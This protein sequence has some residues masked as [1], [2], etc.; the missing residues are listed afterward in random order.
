M[1]LAAFMI[2]FFACKLQV[3]SLR[4]RPPSAKLH[5]SEE[6]ICIYGSAVMNELLVSNLPSFSG[7]ESAAKEYQTKI[8]DAEKA[9][10]LPYYCLVGSQA[11]NCPNHRSR[12]F[13]LNSL[14][15]GRVNE[16]VGEY[17]SALIE[18]MFNV[19]TFMSIQTAFCIRRSEDKNE[20]SGKYALCYVAANLQGGDFE[21]LQ[22]SDDFPE[23][24]GS[25]VAAVDPFAVLD[26]DLKDL[27]QIKQK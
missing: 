13:Y 22:G 8:A 19:S 1:M 12:G 10:K 3:E 11:T 25:D 24:K 7:Y 5:T 20:V 27:A 4:I 6:M 2:F 17:S 18:Y 15:N 16:C 21:S 14:S 26:K 9:M 23:N